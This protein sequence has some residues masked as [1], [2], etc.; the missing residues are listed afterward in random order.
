MAAQPSRAR[1][2]ARQIVQWVYQWMPPLHIGKVQIA[3]PGWI[4]VIG[5]LNPLKVICD[6]V[7][8]WRQ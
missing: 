6:L 3:S 4:E 2:A 5:S 8:S 7:T 1:N